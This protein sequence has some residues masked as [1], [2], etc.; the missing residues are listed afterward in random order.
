M[1]FG[2]SNQTASA[3]RSG[4]ST[5]EQ[6]PSHDEGAWVSAIGGFGSTD[7][8]SGSAGTRSRTGG[9]AGGFDFPLHEEELTAGV[10]FGYVGS[11]TD[12]DD[13]GGSASSKAGFAGLYGRLEKWGIRLDGT[14]MGGYHT[15]EQKRN[16]VIG[17]AVSTA[18]SDFDGYSLGGGLQASKGFDLVQRGDFDAVLR[19]YVGLNAQRYWQKAYSETGAG[20]ANLTYGS[21]TRD[22]VVGRLG[23]V[24]EFGF[25]AGQ[26]TRIAPLVSV[27]LAHTFSDT[28]PKMDA[29]FALLP[30]Q[31]FS[32]QGAKMSPNALELG[33]GLDLIELDSGLTFTIGYGGTISADAQ[34]HSFNLRAKM[35]L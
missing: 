35:A 24:W 31:R 30:D 12:I 15:A 4:I 17:T 32:V 25:M 20:T 1:R 14:L 7:A 3:G 34:D 9:L 11:N 6:A 2:S 26:T 23:T 22:T 13:N 21:M 28:A 8:K 5:G 19:P 33:L 27:G 18:S 16:I 29:A 10:S